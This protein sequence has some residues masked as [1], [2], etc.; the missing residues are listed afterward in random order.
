M[1]ASSPAPKTTLLRPDDLLLLEFDFINLNLEWGDNRGTRLVPVS[2]KQAYIIIHFP[3]Q[4]IAEEAIFEDS[5]LKSIVND[6]KYKPQ[7]AP[8]DPDVKSFAQ[9]IGSLPVKSRLSGRSRL[10]FD[11]PA[12]IKEIPYTIQGLLDWS[13]FT[14]RVAPTALPRGEVG[15][16]P[17][18]VDP[19]SIDPP[20]TTLELPYRLILSPNRTA[21]WV[22][23]SDLAKV[24]HDGRTELW[25]TRLGILKQKGAKQEVQEG[26][27]EITVR[28]I[29]SPDYNPDNHKTTDSPAFND[30]DKPFRMSL[31]AFDRHQIVRLSADY[32][33]KSKPQSDHPQPKYYDPEPIAVDKL[34]LSSLGAWMNT[35]GVWND[36]D[37]PVYNALRL[38]E[39]LIVSE[40]RHVASQGRDQY[41][42]VV[43]QGCLFPFGNKASLIKVTERKVAEIKGG[44]LNGYTIAYLSQRM[45]I[46][47]RQPE[48]AYPDASFGGTKGRDNPF[49]KSIK[50][51]NLVTPDIVD[52]STTGIP[53]TGAFWVKVMVNGQP[54]PFPFHIVVKDEDDKLSEFNAALI[55]IP[56]DQCAEWNIA[57]L[58]RDPYRNSADR[59]CNLHGQ[60]VAFAKRNMSK[61]GDT[62][63][64]TEEMYFD[65][66]Q[67]VQ[68]CPLS[69][70]PILDGEK[71]ASVRIPAVEQLLGTNKAINIK[72]ADAYVNND[73]PLGGK[74]NRS[75]IFVSLIDSPELS[76]PPDKAGGL[77]APRM[78][79]TGISQDMGPVAGK[80]EDLVSGKFT[81]GDFFK[82]DAKLLGGI[83]LQD[84]IPELPLPTPPDAF[85]EGQFKG[86]FPKIT[87][88]Q[89]PA[90]ESIIATLDWSSEVQQSGYFYPK[91]NTKLEI[92]STIE[93]KISKNSSD[94]SEPSYFITGNLN[95]FAIDFVEIIK[96]DFKSLSF[97]AKKGEKMDVSADIKGVTF[98]GPLSFVSTLAEYLPSSSN[99]GFMDPPSVDVSS[100]G[101]TVGYTMGLPPIAVGVFSLQN[102]NLSAGLSLPFVDKSAGLNF[103]FSE[104]H[105]PFL[106]AV[107][108]FAGGGFFSI[109]LGPGNIQMIEASLEFGGNISINLGVASGGVYVMAGIYFKYDNTVSPKKVDVT[110]YFRCGGALE[111]LGIISISVE[112]YL[113]LSYGT[114]NK[115]SGQATLTVTVEV[116]FF[117]KSV[118]LTVEKTFAGAGNDPTFGDLISTYDDWKDYAL[119]FA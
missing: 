31:S 79:L 67:G 108:L 111:I 29:W 22:H 87:T 61:E 72:Q 110:G 51:T 16:R 35:S 23:L 98:E 75:G 63:L 71:A 34:M 43:Y 81:P 93:K 21:G 89:D 65:V 47:V 8:D 26:T 64:I 115:V 12:S 68:S 109:A 1:T 118:H 78:D 80:L 73:E 104:R 92:H 83:R 7:Y 57:N 44:M 70:V 50:V 112:F 36:P 19:G 52:P 9:D 77:A 27:G 45:Y 105:H 100:E 11:L 101:V 48:I 13:E 28:A 3:P 97:R 94:T 76:V 14:Q 37:E 66:K 54:K 39:G 53:G 40:W 32:H 117:S 119:A 58:V 46:V 102:V 107:S 91:S 103:A 20:V 90:S 56:I 49:R 88:R 86:R 84:I 10:V 4:N 6:S 60:K 95:D 30:P 15:D 25:H 74:T 59:A 38:D 41:A 116:L 18:I 2:G 5:N 55:F 82:V 106:L 17:V 42:R 62:T 96:V 24:T 33:I 113:G 85:D 99:P 114:N 69:Y